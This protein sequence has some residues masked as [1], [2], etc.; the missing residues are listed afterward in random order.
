MRQ[1]CHYIYEYSNTLNCIRLKYESLNLCILLII[2]IDVDECLTDN[3][4]CTHQCN[5]DIG[6]YNC[7]CWDG[8]ELSSDNHTCIGKCTFLVAAHK[9][10]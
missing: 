10:C 9:V 4:G 6:S 7:S 5:N 8:Y 1:W 3:G 2:F